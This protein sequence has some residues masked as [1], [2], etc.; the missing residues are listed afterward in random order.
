MSRQR[1]QQPWP[2]RYERNTK[3][4]EAFASGTT[5]RAIGERFGLTF[6]AVRFIL[7]EAGVDTGSGRQAGA[8]AV[9]ED[10]DREI[11][12]A[13]VAGETLAAI[14]ERFEITRQRV[15]QIVRPDMAEED[16]DAC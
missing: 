2:V 8:P 9:N 16:G 15:Q 14:G 4:V 13:R 1:T 5:L 7:R 3:I 12:R 10:R 11:R 6:G